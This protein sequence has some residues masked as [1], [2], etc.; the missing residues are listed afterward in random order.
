MPSRAS[1][2]MFGSADSSAGVK[3]AAPGLV[4]LRGSGIVSLFHNL[5]LSLPGIRRPGAGQRQRVHPRSSSEKIAVGSVAKEGG[6]KPRRIHLCVVWQSQNLPSPCIGRASEARMRPKMAGES[7]A[8]ELEHS[9]LPLVFGRIRRAFDA[10][11]PMQGSAVCLTQVC[12]IVGMFSIC[13]STATMSVGRMWCAN[14]C[15]HR[16]TPTPRPNN[17]TEGV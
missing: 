17:K 4:S 7:G 10:A 15:R 5:C 9:S 14:T 13:Q 11:H 3:S 16:S 12:K 6:K 1:C 8:S 2:L